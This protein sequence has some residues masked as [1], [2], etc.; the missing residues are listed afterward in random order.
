M[1]SMFNW[2][3]TKALCGTPGQVCEPFGVPNNQSC[4]QIPLCPAC[5]VPVEE[6]NSGSKIRLYPNPARDAATLEIEDGQI[7][8]IV[9][10]NALGQIISV[11]QQPASPYT[12][13]LKGLANGLYWMWAKP[14]NGPAEM[15]RL[16]KE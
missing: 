16:L 7:A 10:Y 15:L 14:E 5:Q 12:C 1:E 3:K 9:L 8:Q 13:N 11:W 4:A 6:P 2:I